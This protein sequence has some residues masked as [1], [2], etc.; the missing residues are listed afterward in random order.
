MKFTL[1]L[2]AV[3]TAFAAHALPLGDTYVAG[4]TWYDVQHDGSTG[5]SVVVDDNHFAW[6]VWTY[7]ADGTPSG[8]RHVYQNMWDPGTS[9]FPQA[10]T[11]LDNLLRAGYATMAFTH[12]N[13]PVTAYNG[14]AQGDYELAIS[15]CG[16][17]WTA[18]ASNDLFALSP[19]IAISADTVVHLFAVTGTSGTSAPLRAGYLRGILHFGPITPYQVE[20]GN[21][22]LLDTIPTPSQTICTLFQSIVV[23]GWLKATTQSLYGSE[24]I[25]Q[26]SDDNGEHWAAPQNVTQWLPPDW[27]CPSGETRLCDRDTLRAFDDLSL[28]GDL[29][30]ALHAAFTATGYYAIE[31]TVTQSQSLIWHWNEAT[32]EF[33]LV[34]DGW[35]DAPPPGFLQSIVQRPSLC[36]DPVIGHLYCAYMRYDTATY[37][38]AGYPSADIFVSVS[39]DNGRNW[40]V[41]TNVTRTTPAGHP[42]P[43]GQSLSEREESLGERVMYSEGHGYLPLTYMLDFDAGNSVRGEGV[44]TNNQIVYQRVPVDSI[45]TTPLLPRRA[46]HSD[47]TGFPSTSDR[48]PSRHPSSFALQAFPSPFNNTAVLRFELPAQ[49]KASVKIFDLLGREVATLQSGL[50]NAGTHEVRWNAD[51]YSSGI[52]FARLSSAEQTRTLKLM[53]LK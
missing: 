34:A 25:V 35:I 7:G 1:I 37:T 39:T 20:W 24:V 46:M 53:L 36:V 27:D 2:I 26:I 51:S 8:P 12:A 41:G 31:G 28:V 3:L 40:S 23:R 19:Q 33:S 5:R 50:L 11:Q 6:I 47:S 16:S 49:M 44:A 21:W 4:T 42:V 17:E 14:L 15:P 32:R 29:E 38:E 9:T 30:G 45:P 48:P 22:E 13:C 43:V 10:A 52:Y 18:P